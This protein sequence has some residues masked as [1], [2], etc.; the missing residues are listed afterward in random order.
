MKTEREAV[1]FEV[2]DPPT[3]PRSP[4]AP[5]RP[6]LLF[7]VLIVGICG[8]CAGAF[9]LSRVRSVFSTTAGLERSTGL[10][11]LGAISQ[12]LTDAARALRRK[13]MKY[14]YGASAALGGLFV[15]LLAV[16]FVQRGMVA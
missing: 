13:R 12:N 16:E 4:V 15:V 10:P 6:V 1:K 3:T 8:G 9:A 5:N 2:V 7:G 14:F 11:V